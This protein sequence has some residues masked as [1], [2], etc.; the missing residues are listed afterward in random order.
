MESLQLLLDQFLDQFQPSGEAESLWLQ[1]MFSFVSDHLSGPAPPADDTSLTGVY[2]LSVC[3]VKQIQQSCVTHSLPVS[4]RPVCVS[5]LL[6]RQHLSCFSHLSWSTNQHRAWVREAEL[7]A[8]GQV[9]PRVSL[10]LIGCLREGR[11]G[12]WRLTDSSGSV[13]C[14]C[15]SPS[16]LWLN[17]PVFLPHW[18][19]IPHDVPG[20][21]EAGGWVELIGPPVVLCPGAEQGLAVGPEEGAG[22]SKAVGVKEATDFLKNRSRGQRLSLVGQVISVCPQLDVSGTSFFCFSLA[23]DS[24]P[25]SLPVSP[26]VSLPVLVKGSR[27]WWAQCVCVGQ[28]V[29]VTAL[30]VCVLRGW[31]GNNILCVTERSEIHT[32]Y[33]HPAAHTHTPAATA[34]PP[35]MSQVEDCEETEP[36]RDVGQSAVRMKKSRVISYQGTVTEVVS[37]G[38]GLYVMDRRVGLCLAYQPALRRKLRTGDTLEL[39]H[40]H[41][42]YRP[43]PDFLP[44]MLCTCLRSSVRVTS[45]SG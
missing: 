10:L 17:R 11:D 4:Y 29:C 37:E 8:P 2:Q 28:R 1:Q 6:S 39:H 32:D 25:V 44:S 38:A 45:F 14:E 23:D 7:S 15:L 41:F 43:C 3:V 9:L 42:L 20:S 35:V 22:L 5:E 19:Y 31:R 34:P 26:P 21:E 30:R 12:E 40:V 36:E 33:T 18:N 24:A 16:P 27:L 13:R